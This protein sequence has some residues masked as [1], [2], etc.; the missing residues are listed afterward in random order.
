MSLTETKTILLQGKT[1][2][3]SA[4]ETQVRVAH[5]DLVLYIWK[6][7]PSVSEMHTQIFVAGELAYLR[8]L[9]PRFRTRLSS[10]DTAKFEPISSDQSVQLVSGDTLRIG[11]FSMNYHFRNKSHYLLSRE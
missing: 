8:N 7:A 6:R 11:I 5:S 2:I 1:I 10:K 3:G 4:L 9:A